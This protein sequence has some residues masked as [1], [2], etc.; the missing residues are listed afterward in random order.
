MTIIGVALLFPYQAQYYILYYYYSTDREQ[1]GL[2]WTSRSGEAG[3]GP[4]S[5]GSDV[6]ALRPPV[7]RKELEQASGGRC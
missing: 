2:T 4:A 6:G 7:W 3:D 1:A 5:D